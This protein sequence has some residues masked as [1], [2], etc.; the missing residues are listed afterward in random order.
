MGNNAFDYCTSLTSVNLPQSLKKIGYYG[1]S[2]VFDECISLESITIPDGVESINLS[3]FG[4]GSFV[5]EFKGIPHVY[6]N[7][8]A[9]GA[10][11]RA[12]AV[13]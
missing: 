8:N 5:D 12:L 1:G 13:N 7:G 11:W 2:S 6:Y 10:S 3:A 9:E 4:Y